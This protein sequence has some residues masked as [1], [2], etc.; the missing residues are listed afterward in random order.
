MADPLLDLT[1]IAERQ[2]IAIDGTKYEILSLGELS[3]VDTKRFREWGSRLSDLLK[4]D[5]LDDEQ[6]EE[7]IDTLHTMT[8]RIMVG[9]PADVANRLTDADRIRVAEVFMRLPGRATPARKGTKTK[10]KKSIGAKRSRASNGSTAAT[11]PA[12]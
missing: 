7:L 3:I 6:S 5:S 12:G 11:P 1:T 9:V 8:G 2:T 4:L 10:A